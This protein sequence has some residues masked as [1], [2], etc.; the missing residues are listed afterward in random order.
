M[1]PSIFSLF[2]ASYY[3]LAF[4][5]SF[6][7]E[8]LLAH[9]ICKEEVARGKGDVPKTREAWDSE[10]ST[11]NWTFMASEQSR[12]AVIAGYI[13][14][15]SCVLDVGCGEGL[16]FGW[17]RAR[18]YARYIGLDVSKVAV[19]KL[20]ARRERGATFLQADAEE[21]QL[22]ESDPPMDAIVFNETLYYFREPLVTLKRY[23]GYLK[24]DGVIIVSTYVRS[25][26]ALAI[27]RQVRAHFDLVEETRMT[28][29]ARSWFC[30][31][32]EFNHQAS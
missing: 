19:S 13:K 26:R 8:G 3:R 17:I 15:G 16:L 27:L 14:P 4:G 2:R 5:R 1:K 23:A 24:P 9:L 28:Q 32:L 6:P 21:F 11:G 10:Y 12:Y 18:G 7:L 31:V 22:A 25:K 29:G 20:A 30:T